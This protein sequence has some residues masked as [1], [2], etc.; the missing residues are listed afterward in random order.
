MDFEYSQRTKD[1]QKKLTAFM[2]EHIYPNEDKYYA[3]TNSDKR[4][5]RRLV[6]PVAR[7]DSG[8]HGTGALVE[9]GVQL[10]ARRHR[11]H[12]DDRALRQRGA[13]EAVARPAARRKDPLGF[14]D[15]RAIGGAPA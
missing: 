12:G 6:D 14:S 4:G 10:L 2:D 7:A 5:G 8:D 11:Q 9:R 13:E 15:D 3:H 1:L